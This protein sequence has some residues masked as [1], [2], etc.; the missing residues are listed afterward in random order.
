MAEKFDP[1]FDPAFQPGYDPSRDAVRRPAAGREPIVPP[2]G[3][4]DEPGIEGSA[5]VAPR[6]DDDDEPRAAALIEP[7]PFER[8]LWM[9][10]AGLVLGGIAITFW[11]NSANYYASGSEWTWQQVLQQSSWALSTPMITIGLA[12]GVGLLFRRAANWR[13]EA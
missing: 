12:T 6:A 4:A 2:A 8:I 10:T 9:V 3:L 13:P 1:R 5:A 11:S 7:N